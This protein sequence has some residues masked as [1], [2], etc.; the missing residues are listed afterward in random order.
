MQ[1]LDADNIDALVALLDKHADKALE[2]LKMNRGTEEATDLDTRTVIW[3]QMSA[4]LGEV[5]KKE[6][7]LRLRLQLD[8]DMKYELKIPPTAKLVD[9]F[10]GSSEDGWL[11]NIDKKLVPFEDLTEIEEE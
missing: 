5:A 10:F 9:A 8:G 7:P 3:N 11:V 2:Y 6:K 1:I 4:L